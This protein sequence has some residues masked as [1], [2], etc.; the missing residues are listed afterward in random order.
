M[1][2]VSVGALAEFTVIDYELPLGYGRLIE[3]EINLTLYGDEHFLDRYASDY[4]TVSLTGYVCIDNDTRF[5]VG[6]GT[7]YKG[8]YTIGSDK[9]GLEFSSCFTSRKADPYAYTEIT[10]KPLPDD[11]VESDE[12]PTPVFYEVTSP[13]GKRMY[14]LGTIHVG[15]SRTAY[16]PTEILEAL[17]RSDALAVE[18][19]TDGLKNRIIEDPALLIAYMKGSAYQD[20]TTVRDHIP[21]PLY[22]KNLLL[23]QLCGDITYFDYYLPSYSANLF[24]NYL[25][26][27]ANALYSEKGIEQRL[28]RIA[29]DNGIEI[30]E[31][32]DISLS[33]SRDSAYSPVTQTYLLD[34][35]LSM[36][37]SESLRATLGLY[38][39]WCEGD[40]QRIREY[41]EDDEGVGDDADENER[42]ATEEYNRI[43]LDE[44]DALM[45]EKAKEYMNSDKTV[46][47]AVGLAHLLGEGGIVDILRCDGYSVQHVAFK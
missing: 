43:L 8:E 32:E 26:R 2:I 29:R 7:K 42:I 38:E 20:N 22:Q 13:E 6:S 5:I 18:I 10:G 9:F 35:A 19:D 40:E 39:L 12:M 34:S 4:R 47:M 36:T 21:K 44:R 16:L 17:R 27:S 23:S 14:L 24:N 45:V 28:K 41:L 25:I 31:V 37:R 46:F 11:E 3:E 30:V 33:L 1:N 15:D